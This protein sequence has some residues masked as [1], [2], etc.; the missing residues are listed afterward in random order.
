MLAVLSSHPEE[1]LIKEAK[2]Y[3]VDHYFEMALGSSMDKSEGLHR[4][5]EVLGVNRKAAI[6]I[7]DTVHDLRAAK[8]VDVHSAGVCTGYHTREMLARE[9]PDFLMENLSDLK[10]ILK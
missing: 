2:D 4:I 8:S 5:L 1:N 10:N 6:F 3:G 7:G 9:E